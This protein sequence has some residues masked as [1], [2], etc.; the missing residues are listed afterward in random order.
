VIGT[1]ELKMRAVA[2]GIPA[3]VGAE[4]YAFTQ[5]EAIDARRGWRHWGR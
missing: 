1:R 2:A 3:V 5:F 4:A